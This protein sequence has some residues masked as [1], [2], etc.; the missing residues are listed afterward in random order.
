[1]GQFRGV[2]VIQP[3]GVVPVYSTATTI[4]PGSWIS[5]FGSNLASGTT[6][7]NGDFQ[8][9]LGAVTVTINNRPGYL[10]YVSPGQINVQAPDD[11][12]TGPVNVVVTNPLGSGSTTVTLGPYSPSF[13]LLDNKHVAG[14]ILRSDGSGS[15]G[16][17][18]Y[19]ILGPT[20]TS[21]GYRT[22]AAKAGD[23]IALFG[24]GFGPTTPA[25]PA[26][27]P[28]SGSAR[29]TNLVQV[30]INNVLVIP[31]FSGLSSAGLYQINLTIPPGIGAGDVSLQAAVGGAQTQAGVV[32]SLQDVPN[33]TTIRS[34]DLEPTVVAGGFSSTGRVTLTDV[35]PTA[36]AVVSLSSS[37]SAASAPATVTVSR[38][39]VSATFPVSTATVT[40][41]QTVAIMATYNGSTASA[42]ITVKSAA[43]T[44]LKLSGFPIFQPTG[45]PSDTFNFE[46]TP[47]AGNVTYTANVDSGFYFV[48]GTVSNQGKTFTFNQVRPAFGNLALFDYL[49]NVIQIFSGTMNLTLAPNSSPSGLSKSGKLSGTLSLTGTNYYPVSGGAVNLSGSIAGDYYIPQ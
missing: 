28:F 5:I 14:I 37:G 30:R 19:D 34:L 20:G 31:T 10:W 25:V 27:K 6:I 40:S 32:F 1:L 29:T 36:G 46:L 24:V 41:D 18:T 39:N 49:G 21:L 22:V 15:N 2:P 38:F 11:T 47:D 17:G 3:N 9:S 48:G 23:N 43:L 44:F 8:T 45:S 33:T 26:G 4:Q 7:W 35:A 13:S 12:T 42:N 16:G